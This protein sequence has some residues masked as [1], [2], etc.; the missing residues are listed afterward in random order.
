MRVVAPPTHVGEDHWPVL[1]CVRV[2]AADEPAEFV[3]L[4]DCGEGTPQH[5]YATLRVFVWPTRRKVADGEYNLSFDQA[6]RSLAER[7]RLLPHTTS[8]VEVVVVRDPDAAND[9][10]IFVD[11]THRPDGK[12]NGVRVVTHDIDLGAVEI[13][14]AWVE[15]QLARASALSPAAARHARDAVHAHVEDIE[16]DDA[17]AGDIVAEDAA[18]AITPARA[19]AELREEPEGR[20]CEA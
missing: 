7:A 16:L 18:P 2:T 3:V 5:P 4:V 13:T 6:R 14:A 1:S 15:Q 8:S 20:E 19:E 9:Y 11:G 17:Q 10:A 12:A